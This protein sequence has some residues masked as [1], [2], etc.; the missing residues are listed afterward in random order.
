MRK[1]GTELLWWRLLARWKQVGGAMWVTKWPC[2]CMLF[3]PLVV[4]HALLRAAI[5]QSGGG[6]W[7]VW[8][9]VTAVCVLHH[10]SIAACVSK[11]IT[12]VPVFSVFPPP[13]FCWISSMIYTV[14]LQSVWRLFLHLLLLSE[15]LTVLNPEPLVVQLLSPAPP[16]VFSC[17]DFMCYDLRPIPVLISLSPPSLTL[18]LHLSH[19]LSTSLSLRSF[20]FVFYDLWFLTFKPIWASLTLSLSLSLSLSFS[21]SLV[22]MYCDFLP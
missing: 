21:P 12:P 17:T 11:N 22:F 13:F 7:T 2:S 6:E 4:H 18:S 9:K 8:A 5:P 20:L 3:L 1:G 15:Y 10:F 14:F 19:L 16:F